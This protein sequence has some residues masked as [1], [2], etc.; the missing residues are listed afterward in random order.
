[1]MATHMLR[2]QHRHIEQGLAILE[3]Q[4]DDCESD[5]EALVVELTAHLAAEESVFYPGAEQALGQTLEEQRRQHERVRDAVSKAARA[6]TD[7]RK[8]PRLL[9]NLTEAFRAH[10]RAEER[11]VHPSLEGVLGDRNLEALGC[12]VAAFYAA[13]AGAIR[14]AKEREL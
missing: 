3:A 6:C 5:F 8:F 7:A 11:A 10:T 9:F 13:V 1:M 2:Q 12:E 4:S 14:G